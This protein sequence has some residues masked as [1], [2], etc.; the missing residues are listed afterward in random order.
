MLPIYRERGVYN[1]Y[2]KLGAGGSIAPLEEAPAAAAAS[3]S[4]PD[5]EALLKT[6]ESDKQLQQEIAEV[7]AKRASGGPRPR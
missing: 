6:I 2:S 5:S 7:I 4:G 1:C 3:S